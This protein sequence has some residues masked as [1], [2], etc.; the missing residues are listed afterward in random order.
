MI[1]SDVNVLV[2]A[3][4]HDAV[5]HDRFRAWL[6]SVVNGPKT[7]GVAD[8]VLSGFVRI[9]TH[10]RIFDPPTTLGEA[11][12]FC[13]FVRNGEHARVVVPGPLHWEIF[14]DL[15]RRVGAKGPLV[16]DAYL[17]ALAIESDCELIT[18]DRDFARFPGLRWRRP[19]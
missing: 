9:V 6:E 3:H 11:L 7:Y 17:A 16:S 8:L 12:E 10:P 15:C 4:R 19:F 1:L 2:Y 5:D 13:A 14:I 18:L